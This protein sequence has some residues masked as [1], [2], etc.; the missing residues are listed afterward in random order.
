MEVAHEQTGQPV[1]CS[2]FS[3]VKDNVPK[4]QKATWEQLCK[5][6]ETP[7]IAS[8]K[9][10]VR[11]FSP[12]TFKDGSKRS[13]QNVE[14]IHMALLDM[15][16]GHDP[17]DFVNEWSK[18]GIEFI[19]Y[20]TWSHTPEVPKWRAIFPLK[21]PVGASEWPSV[22]QGIADDLGHGL[23][24][25]ACRDA[26]RMYYVPCCSE[27]RQAFFAFE[28][29][30]GQWLDATGY[31]NSSVEQEFIASKENTARVGGRV[32]DNFEDQVSIDE[33]LVPHGWVKAKGFTSGLEKWLR[34]GKDDSGECSATFGYRTAL[35][36]DRFFLFSSSVPG[37][38]VRTMLTKFALYT[39]LNHAGDFRAAAR[40][41]TKEGYGQLQVVTQT[42]VKDTGVSVGVDLSEEEKE[43]EFTDSMNG[44]RLERLFGGEFRFVAEM[45]QWAAWD[46]CRW[47][48]GPL[49]ESKI[50]I[51][52]IESARAFQREAGTTRDQTRAQKILKWAISSQN[53]ARIDAA[54]KEV[55]PR[56]T[57]SI[58][59]FDA[60]PWILNCRNCM[61]DLRTGEQLPHDRAKLIS[62]VTGCDYATDKQV[63]THFKAFLE[64]VIPDASTREYLR[65]F[66]GYSLTGLTD[67]QG[68]LF[69]H[70]QTGWNGKSTLVSLL[71]HIFGDYAVT[72]NTDGI[73][74][75]KG[76]QSNPEY[77]IARLK[78]KR[79]AAV[80]EVSDSQRMNEP[81]IKR[82]TGGDVVQ[83]RHPYGKSFEFP[84]I[85]KIW[86]TGNNK[87]AIYGQ[88]SATWRRVNLMP[89]D[90]TIPKEERDPK[91]VSKMILEA[92]YI[93]RQ[94]V[95]WCL[96]WQQHSLSPSEQMLNE[97]EEYEEEN[98]FLGV[99]LTE[100]CEFYS[101]FRI[102]CSGLHQHYLDWARRNGCPQMNPT[103]FGRMMTSRLGKMKGVKKKRSQSG[104][105]WEGMHV[106][107][108][109]QK[110]A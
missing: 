49:A 60:D 80:N 41:L 76:F 98:D 24:D 75:S 37:I 66:I 35:G 13:A 89:F 90:V 64:R 96:E 9:K 51:F 85:A 31:L 23:A 29:H 57:V 58:N 63:P 106:K 70:G 73:M 17:T 36:G 65:R 33:I 100:E 25:P 91:L 86:M 81:L 55:K 26:C 8:E 3:S 97:K 2:F 82:L 38:P 30:P 95:G 34:P 101:G 61:I 53:T 54:I 99:F 10:N 14:L 6:F 83:G 27:D 109:G 28:H 47:A 48:I 84:A 108:G 104:L 7:E 110:G 11:L 19:V 71:Q 45:N 59:A 42:E 5:K 74:V 102:S 15:D 43:R 52:A 1:E 103:A 56:V 20:T 32:G 50:R 107:D 87:P 94:F 69:C 12:A 79:F 92:P 39:Y 67:E 88:D 78:G 62:Q 72:I 21:E 93:L 46:G 40:A 18:K 68:F 4:R 22:W 16:G 105:F 77:E 44:V